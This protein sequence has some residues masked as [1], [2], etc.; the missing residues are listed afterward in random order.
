MNLAHDSYVPSTFLPR[1]SV[2]VVK[3]ANRFKRLREAA[4]EKARQE[5]D[6]LDMEMLRYNDKDAMRVMAKENLSM[7]KELK[8]MRRMMIAH[9]NHTAE[10]MTAILQ[11]V[12]GSQQQADVGTHSTVT[13]PRNSTAKTD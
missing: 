8:D 3:A 7:H 4:R 6:A 12:Q 13:P 9:A 5:A 2:L 1:E 11:A 10:Q